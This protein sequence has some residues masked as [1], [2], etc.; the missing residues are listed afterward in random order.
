MAIV[1]IMDTVRDRGSRYAVSGGAVEHA[2][3]VRA[4]LGEV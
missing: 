1:Q 3:A 4:C 2:A